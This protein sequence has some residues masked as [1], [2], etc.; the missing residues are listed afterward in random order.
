MLVSLEEMA[1]MLKTSPA[2]LTAA[3]RRLG[4]P[5]KY[6]TT[7]KDIAI[8]R[9]EVKAI[10]SRSNRNN[11]NKINYYN[12]ALAIL[13]RDGFITRSNLLEVFKTGETDG[14]QTYFEN[15]ENPLYHEEIEVPIEQ[16]RKSKNYNIK[17]RVIFRLCR[18]KYAEWAEERR[19]NGMYNNS[20]SGNPN[21][22][23]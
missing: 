17:K 5:A 10:Q 9:G 13:E 20:Y 1:K 12:E 6:K 3:K 11:P 7:D 18:V 23:F 4:Y 16:K 21:S 14:I 22:F 15:K 8:L 19:I 2:T